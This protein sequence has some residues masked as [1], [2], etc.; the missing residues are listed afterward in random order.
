MSVNQVY[1]AFA[2]FGFIL[3]NTLF[4]ILGG[5]YE[6]DKGDKSIILDLLGLKIHFHHWML[7]FVLLVITLFIE[8]IFSSDNK[9]LFVSFLKGTFFGMMFHG[10]AFYTDY[11]QIFKK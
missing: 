5:G 2:L 9:N 4:L 7:G 3:S 11:F 10:I 1:Y 6:G 8:T